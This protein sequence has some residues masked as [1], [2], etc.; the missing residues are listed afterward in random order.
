M[1]RAAYTAV[2]L[3]PRSYLLWHMRVGVFFTT[4]AL[5]LGLE[6]SAIRIKWQEYPTA[7]LIFCS[8]LLLLAVLT[9]IYSR[10]AIR[11][12]L[13]PWL[14]FSVGVTAIP[15]LI[16]WTAAS[17][18]STYLRPSFHDSLKLLDDEAQMTLHKRSTW[19]SGHEWKDRPPVVAVALSGGGY[20]AAAVHAGLLE[21]LDKKCLP[22]RYLTTVSGGSIVGTYYSL[23]YSPKQFIG[24]I[25]NNRPGL[26]DFML[27][28]WYLVPEWFFPERPTYPFIP[29]WSSAD[30]LGLHLAKSFFGSKT[31]V[32]TG[33]TPQILINATDLDAT[34]A[35]E[36]F[37]K[38]RSAD[39]VDTPLAD[40]VAASAAFPGAFLPKSIAWP[41]SLQNTYMDASKNRRF[42]DGGVLENL[43]YT[44]LAL[45]LE[46]ETSAPKPDLFIVSDVSMENSSRTFQLKIDPLTLLTRSESISYSLEHEFLR[47]YYTRP[48]QDIIDHLSFRDVVTIRPTD[49]QRTLKTSFV[50]DPNGACPSGTISGDKVAA[51]VLRYETMRELSPCEVE[52][53][54]WLGF[55]LAESFWKE[56]I[57]S[58]VARYKKPSALECDDPAATRKSEITLGVK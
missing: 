24:K 12:G 14:Q 16:A 46:Q 49:E 8:F 43:G 17:L 4:L 27:S 18:S 57:G 9:W 42:V 47:E 54:F 44:G 1:W 55:Q 28:M 7:G 10:R 26:P 29:Y 36:V 19:R 15:L 21:F 33:D 40:V 13:T 25:S 58:K 5:L 2:P 11:A 39:V 41:K 30:T 34:W 53:A 6:A 22:I 37:Y 31:F 38:G 23:G 52:K 20:R 3:S 45:F 35:R 32:D 56:K 51:D 48:P 50:P